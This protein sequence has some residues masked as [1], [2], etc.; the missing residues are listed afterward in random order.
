MIVSLCCS[1][2]ICFCTLGFPQK[3]QSQKAKNGFLE[4]VAK[5]AEFWRDPWLLR[6]RERS[7]VQVAVPRIVVPP[8][9]PVTVDGFGGDGE[10]ALSAQTKR[11]AM[12]KKAA[13]ASLE[14]EDYARRFESGD[15]VV[16]LASLVFPGNGGLNMS[17]GFVLS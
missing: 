3:L 9:L 12:Q 2:R 16:S 11:A 6:V 1:K 7:T 8:P 17:L 14:A 10:E 5:V 15:L 13:A 4:E